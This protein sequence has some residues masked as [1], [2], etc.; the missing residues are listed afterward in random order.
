MWPPPLT[1][2]CRRP[3]PQQRQLA[4]SL[5]EEP[6]AA[7]FPAPAALEPYAPLRPWPLPWHEHA[8]P[9]PAWPSVLALSSPHLPSPLLLFPSSPAPPSSYLS[10]TPSLFPAPHPPAAGSAPRRHAAGIAP[11]ASP[12][13]PPP[14]PVCGALLQLSVSSLPSHALSVQLPHAASAPPPRAPAA[15]APPRPRAPAAGAPPQPSGD[16]RPPLAPGATA[17]PQPSGGTPF[18][19]TPCAAAPLLHVFSSPPLP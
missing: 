13:A 1:H 11:A 15:G 10:R 14:P 4:L 3:T 8:A 9:P 6:L 19:P 16:A 18:P 5:F 2:H 7:P 12:S 17:P